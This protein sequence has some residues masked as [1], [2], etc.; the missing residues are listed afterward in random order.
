MRP[1]RFR[2]FAVQS[3]TTAG[4]A[5][6][7]WDD[8]NKRPLGV[9][10]TLPSGA[11]VWHAV[12]VQSPEGEK[13]SEP[14]KIVEGDAP[15]SEP[16]PDLTSRVPVPTVEAFLAGTIRNAGST[17]VSGVYSY[18][19]RETPSVHPGFG[20]TFHSGAK[21]FCVFVHVAGP[22]QGRPGNAYDIP[23]EV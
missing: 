12:T 16:L 4:L 2:D 23:T 14:E 3:Y 6:E 17:E 10:V 20:V 1:E 18:S 7:P 5:A 13:S 11:Q 19:G 8:G 21:A 9:K 22:G 15:A